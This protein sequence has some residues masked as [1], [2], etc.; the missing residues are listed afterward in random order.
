M[1]KIVVSI[2]VASLMLVLASGASAATTVTVS[3]GS[4]A[5]STTVTLTGAGFDPS[6]SVDVF[7]DTTDVAIATSN[8]SG[9]VSFKLQIPASTQPG[10]HWITLD[11]PGNHRAAQAAFLVFVNWPQ[12]GFGPSKRSFNPYENTINTGNVAQLTPAWSRA[13]D[14]FGN[15]K[16][17]IM[18]DN[19]IY[20]RDADQVIR[21]FST[22][23][24]LEWHAT[25]PFQSFPDALTPA[26]YA[27]KVFFGDLNGNV[28]AYNYLCRT[29]GGTCTRAWAR[30]IGSAVAG[31][32]TVNN[33]LL[34][35]P[36]ADGNVHVLNPST[37]APQTSITVTSNPLTTWIAFG[38]DGGGFVGDGTSMAETKTNTGFFSNDSYSGTLSPPAVGAS[39]AYVTESDDLL[40]EVQF[41]WT[42]ALG[43]SGC[44]LQTPPA[45]ANGVVYAAGC[46]SIGAYDAGNGS[47]LWSIGTPGVS[48]ALTVANGVLYAC[49]NARLVAYDASYGGRLWSGGYCS[50]APIIVN[51][52]LYSTYGDLKAYTLTAAQSTSV[53]HRVRRPDPRRLKPSAKLHRRY[54]QRHHTGHARA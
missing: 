6:V 34:Y 3:P 18:Y 36:A 44:G 10:T 28:N 9:A 37:G 50:A 49:V 12:T 22:T 21:A 53:R 20:I 48:D 46:A 39:N 23:G 17:P 47:T 38:A 30:N 7:V 54:R 8:A 31:G 52:V 15:S 29:D 5:P 27:G 41:S 35:V 33:G 11:E 25:T 32:I 40:R 19:I 43:G 26:A 16:P 2:A 24:K 13:L 51:G 4:G 14:G 45:F 42:T 1:K